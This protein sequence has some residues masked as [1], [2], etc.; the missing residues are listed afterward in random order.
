MKKKKN[1]FRGIIS[2][3]L[4]PLLALLDIVLVGVL[5][6]KLGGYEFP[7]IIACISLYVSFAIILGVLVS[8]TGKKKSNEGAKKGPVLVT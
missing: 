2:F 7:I 5:V 8:V 1:V 4:L 6:S 3:G